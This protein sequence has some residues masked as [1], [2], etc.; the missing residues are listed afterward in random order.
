[1]TYFFIFIILD[2]CHCV[3]QDDCV[4]THSSVKQEVWVYFFDQ[5]NRAQSCS[6]LDHRFFSRKPILFFYGGGSGA[7]RPLPRVEAW[8]NSTESG[9]APRSG[10]EIKTGRSSTK[11]GTPERLGCGTIQGGCLPTS[12]RLN[13][14][15]GS[16]FLY[17]RGGPKWRDNYPEGPD[18]PVASIHLV[19][20]SF[21][22]LLTGIVCFS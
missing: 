16:P 4:I 1:L 11:Y 2:F 14:V 9:H 15:V 18:H 7:T 22:K 21:K 20:L 19:L 17:S 13:V 3:V 10:P 5:W 6:L 8:R 12:R